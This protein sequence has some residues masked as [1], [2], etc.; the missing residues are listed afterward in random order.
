L[1][2]INSKVAINKNRLKHELHKLLLLLLLVGKHLITRH[3]LRLL[4]VLS[5]TFTLAGLFGKQT[6]R[7]EAGD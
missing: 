4:S 7:V 2:A 6:M 1:K 3:S 5:E